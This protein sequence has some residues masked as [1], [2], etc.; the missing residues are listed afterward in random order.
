MSPHSGRK[1]KEAYKRHG[2][3][4]AAREVC[5]ATRRLGDGSR[6]ILRQRVRGSP[7]AVRAVRNTQVFQTETAVVA[8]V[9]GLPECLNADCLPRSFKLNQV[10]GKFRLEQ[11]L[12][13]P[14]DA[15]TLSLQLVSDAL[16][17]SEAPD[18]GFCL[19][20]G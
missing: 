16:C 5:K 7:R 18:Y 13:I 20:I 11:L 8:D 17:I 14:G 10:D 1:V 6:L 3:I 12:F 4:A 15:M 9:H 2:M 19:S